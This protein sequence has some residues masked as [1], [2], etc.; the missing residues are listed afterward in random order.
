MPRVRITADDGWVALDER[1]RAEHFDSDHFRRCIAERLAWATADAERHT[2][3]FA[4]GPAAA[5]SRGRL[6]R[7]RAGH[8]SRRPTRAAQAVQEI[9]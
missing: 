7:V 8:G 5:P 6:R 2:G 3:A 9:T 4:T 1:V